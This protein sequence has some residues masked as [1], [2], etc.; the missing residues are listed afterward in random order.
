MDGRV[1][2][3]RRR[4]KA[5]NRLRICTSWQEKALQ[6]KP[7]PPV[8]AGYAGFLGIKPAKSPA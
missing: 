3:E 4:M 1:A 6:R 5:L 8:R 2:S 7:A